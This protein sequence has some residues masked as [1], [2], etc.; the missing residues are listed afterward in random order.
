VDFK[1]GEFIVDGTM[2]IERAKEL[3]GIAN[4]HIESAGKQ[5]KFE[6]VPCYV[7]L[8]GGKATGRRRFTYHIK[9]K[10]IA[11][12]DLENEVSDKDHAVPRSIPVY[13]DDGERL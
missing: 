6:A 13:R 11:K 8:S 4:G 12:G 3:A 1:H 7:E 9:V 5:G 10:E 2:S